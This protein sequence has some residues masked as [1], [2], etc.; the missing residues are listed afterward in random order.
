MVGWRTMHQRHNAE[1][2][3]CSP[4][5]PASQSAGAGHGAA[6]LNGGSDGGQLPAG[7][8]GCQGGP[9]ELD[10]RALHHGAS[11]ERFGLGSA[12][13]GPFRGTVAH[14]AGAEDAVGA[15]AFTGLCWCP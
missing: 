12:S 4:P 2:S 11:S 15:H 7:V 9:A 14:H 10:P 3:S 13:L 8:E 6:Y 5:N 1:A